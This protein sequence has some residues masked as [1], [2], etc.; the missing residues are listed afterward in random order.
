MATAFVLSDQEYGIIQRENH[1]IF[2][3]KWSL[4]HIV[5][6]IDKYDHHSA[7]KRS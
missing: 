7:E 6:I 5:C 1:L 4:A 2:Y 3:Y